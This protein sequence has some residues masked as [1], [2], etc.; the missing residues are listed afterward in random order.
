MVRRPDQG[1]GRD[2]GRR[3][4]QRAQQ[5]GD[6]AGPIDDE[7]CFGGQLTDLARRAAHGQARVPVPAQGPYRREGRQV[8]Q[9]VTGEQHRP[10]FPFG[11]KGG[12]RRPLVHPRRPQLDDQPPGL[13]H[14][15]HVRG[16]PGQRLPQ[17]SQR[18][19]RIR[20]APRV[21][22]QRAPLVLDPHP[23]GRVGIREQLRQP[24]PRRRHPR[25][26]CRGGHRT[27][28]PP[29]QA[30][31]PEH[32]QP[33]HPLEPPQLHRLGSRPPGNHR[34]R[35]HRPGEPPQ[36]CHRPRVRTRLPRIG[37]DRRE[38][39][40]IVRRDQ[41]PGRVFPNRRQPRPPLGGPGHRHLA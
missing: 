15:P 31:V 12:E 28:L 7:V 21:H 9:V 38:R 37:H 39:P 8:P 17:R 1:A 2:D 27:L 32:D 23:L 3:A 13:H 30:V 18:P 41:R 4:G 5:G 10:G 34:Q 29:L 35:P 24:L 33:G 20:R 22:R 11:N 25:R 14:Q 40:V 19:R 6:P 16:Q 36:S 26:R